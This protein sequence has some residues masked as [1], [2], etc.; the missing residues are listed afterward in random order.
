MFSLKPL[1]AK[2][3]S[4]KTKQWDGFYPRKMF[5]L[6]QKQRGFRLWNQFLTAGNGEEKGFF[7]FTVYRFTLKGALP[8]LMAKNIIWFVDKFQTYICSLFSREKLRS[9][10]SDGLRMYLLTGRATSYS[11][12]FLSYE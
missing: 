3:I 1:Q 4:R 10:F 7:P 2:K 5:C 8:E 6:V 9:I 12:L 11:G